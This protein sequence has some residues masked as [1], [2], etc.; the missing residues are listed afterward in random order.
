M[1]NIINTF[2]TRKEVE[3]YRAEINEMCDKRSEFISLC[4]QANALSEKSFGYIKEAFENI[5]PML[6]ETSEGKK[7]IKKYTKVVREHKNLYSLH[8]IYENI[9]KAGKDMDVDFFV[10]NIANAEW[11][12][13]SSTLKEDTKKL[14]RILSEAYIHLGKEAETMLP[15]ENKTLSSAVEYI[16]ENKKTN[17]N[18]AEY[19]NAVKV[20]RENVEKN[21]TVKNI[22]ET[23][24]LDELAEK[25]IK[26][27]NVKYSDKLSVDEVNILKEISGSQD[28]ESVFN[29]YKEACTNKITEAK[30]AFDAKGDKASSDRLSVVLEQISG[31]SFALETIGTDICSL[32]E[33]SNIFE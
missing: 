21:E 24:N 19:S 10:N 13:N 12:V 11:G 23:V 7:L 17:K 31:K 5:S 1:K 32:I 3:D 22:F 15:K 30:N 26:E 20:I 27:F 9:R 33:L 2:K 16:A 28:R 18:I 4:E 8:S 25:L 6:F 29:K 14:G